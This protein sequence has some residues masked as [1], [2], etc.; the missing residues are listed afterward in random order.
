MPLAM[1]E[2]RLLR[3]GAATE[4]AIDVRLISAS[5]QNLAECFKSGR[6]RQDLYYRLDVVELER[7]PLRKRLNDIGLLVSAILVRLLIFSAQAEHA[8]SESGRIGGITCVCVSR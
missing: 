8:Q 1:Q 6:F 7:P 4:E 5:H 2:R 3:V